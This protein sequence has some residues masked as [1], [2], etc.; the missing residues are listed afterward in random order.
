VSFEPG[1]R[2]RR[3]GDGAF[4]HSS[5]RSIVIP[6]SVCPLLPWNAYDLIRRT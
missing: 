5:L 2:L 3:I 6:G 4:S 1:S